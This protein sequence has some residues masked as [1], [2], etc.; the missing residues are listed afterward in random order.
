[1][2]I[3]AHGLCVRLRSR[4]VIASLDFA[5]QQVGG[6]VL[7]VAQVAVQDFHN[8]EHHVEA[9]Q[10]GQRQRAHGMGHAQFHDGI[11]ALGFG[12]AFVQGKDGFVDH[13]HENAIGDEARGILHHNGRLAHLPADFQ[14]RCQR[15]VAGVFAAHHFEQ[16]H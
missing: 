3:E 12:D 6:L 15:F 8:V 13:R 2:R 11:Y 5:A 1:M 4:E 14:N 7:V 10:I 9:D 16:R